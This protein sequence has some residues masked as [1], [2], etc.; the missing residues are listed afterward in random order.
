[1]YVF[2]IMHLIL[3]CIKLIHFENMIL[4]I[5]YCRMWYLLYIHILYI[6]YFSFE[7]SKSPTVWLSQLVNPAV[8]CTCWYGLA[9]ASCKTFYHRKYR[10]VCLAQNVSLSHVFYS[11][12]GPG[13]LCHKTH[14]DNQFQ[15]CGH[16]LQGLQIGKFIDSWYFLIVTQHFAKDVQLNI[17]LNDSWLHK[18]LWKYN[19]NFPIRWVGGS[20]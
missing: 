4:E 5:R 1:M 17:S 15:F 14:S 2:H 10:T 12:I 16:N 11:W 8:P 3:L 13:T 6:V 7:N 20:P 9:N 19:W 18:K